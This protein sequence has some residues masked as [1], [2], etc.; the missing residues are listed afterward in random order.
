MPMYE[1]QCSECR[2]T[3]TVLSHTYGD[4]SDV[5]CAK[6]GSD[7]MVRLVSSFAYHRSLNSRLEDI[8]TRKPRGDDYYRDSRNVGLWAKKRIRELGADGETVRQIDQVVD[9]AAEKALSGKLLDEI[10]K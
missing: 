5:T 6:C 9:R 7:R 8:D 1:Y 10:G 3:T 2:A 4:V